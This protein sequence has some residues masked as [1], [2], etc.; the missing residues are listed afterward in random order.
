[1]RRAAGLAAGA[2]LALTLLAASPAGAQE[3]ADRFTRWTVDARGGIAVPV[4]DVKDYND[5]GGLA[6]AGVAY[7]VLPRLRLRADLAAELLP[8]ADWSRVPTAPAGAQAEG[9]ETDLLHLTGGL[10]LRLTHPART[11]WTLWLHGGAG[12]TDVS[13]ETTPATQGDNLTRF[14]WNGGVSF[15]YPF[16]DRVDL[17]GRGEV[18]VVA[19]REA[20]PPRLGTVFTLPTSLGLQVHF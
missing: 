1:M 7:R 14:T 6:G 15:E 9:P 10:Q 17:V 11:D 5:L 8:G 19:Q 2:I 13:V 12:W 18:Y 16:S 3:A 20:G 4:G